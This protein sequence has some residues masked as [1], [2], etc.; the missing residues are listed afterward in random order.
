MEA[1]NLLKLALISLPALVLHDY[2]KDTD[3]IILTM[4]ASLEG[5]ER[6]VIQLIKGKRHFF[7]YGSGIW[8][9]IE[10][11]YNATKRKCRGVLKALK[12]VKY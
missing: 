2:S 9:N 6:V 5:W 4:D 11:K 3:K 8:S 10:K 7:R 1:I 12:K